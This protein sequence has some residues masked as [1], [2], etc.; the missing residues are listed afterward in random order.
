MV[1]YDGF[2]IEK[3]GKKMC[4]NVNLI[5]VI[6]KSFTLRPRPDA[7]KSSQG[8]PHVIYCRLWRWPELSV[9]Y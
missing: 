6:F 8:L 7:K 2:S 4:S 1:R 5:S 3:K 9:S